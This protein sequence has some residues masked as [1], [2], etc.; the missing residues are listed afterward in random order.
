MDPTIKEILM[1]GMTE[2]DQQPCLNL[3]Q[4]EEANPEETD[5]ITCKMRETGLSFLLRAGGGASLL[6]M[7]HPY[8]Q[9]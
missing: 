7:K 5:G 3:L 9:V 4:A 8:Q 2:A 6:F 1:H